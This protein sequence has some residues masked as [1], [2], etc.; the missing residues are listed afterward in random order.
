MSVGLSV[1][2]NY[3]EQD[4]NKKYDELK[5]YRLTAPSDP[6]ALGFQGLYDWIANI[7][8][9]KN[10]VNVL[11]IESLVEKER[12]KVQADSAKYVYEAQ[13]DVLLENNPEVLS[14]ASDRIRVARANKLLKAEISRMR[15][16]DLIHRLVAAY[17]K[18][19]AAVFSNL[20]SANLNLDRQSNIYKR[21]N[22]PTDGQPGYTPSYPP[23]TGNNTS[24][25]TVPVS[26]V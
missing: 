22:P 14:A 8:K 3:D 6:V 5:Q 20:E 21:M 16:T 26:P 7:Q 12:A 24:G 9:M 2:V 1:V 19:V 23:P 11:L 10:R 25:V 13:L 15:E 17:H 4:Y 18:S